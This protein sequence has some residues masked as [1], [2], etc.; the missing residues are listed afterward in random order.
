MADNVG[1]WRVDMLVGV[2]SIMISVSVCLSAGV[3]KKTTRTNFSTF[4][5][6]V[7]LCTSGFVN[8][9]VFSYNVENRPDQRRRVYVSSISPGGST[10]R[11]SDN[12][13]WLRSPGSDTD[14]VLLSSKSSLLGLYPRSYC[15]SVSVRTVTGNRINHRRQS[16]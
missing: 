11:T 7:T 1:P 12:V 9:V 3:S 8:D 5:V 16:L 10:S 2:L 6:D 13:V 15:T 14:Y 4:S